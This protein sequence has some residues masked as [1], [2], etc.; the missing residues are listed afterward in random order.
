[1]C[2]VSRQDGRSPW[3]RALASFAL[4]AGLLLWNFARPA[5]GPGHA[6]LDATIGLMMGL[7]IGMNLMLVWKGR[8]DGN[9]GD[10]EF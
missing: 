1:M 7:S 8:R 2:V 10:R 5:H 6:W 9:A 4:V 3:L